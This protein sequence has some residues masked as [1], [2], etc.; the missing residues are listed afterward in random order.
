MMADG[1]TVYTDQATGDLILQPAAQAKSPTQ[2]AA[3]HFVNLAED[4]VPTDILDRLASSTSELVAWDEQNLAPSREL[5]AK[6]IELLGIGEESKPDDA[7]YE[8]S[9]TSDHP[10]LL[11][12]VTRFQSKAL[13]ALL[14][15][16]DRVCR[17]EAAMDLSEIPDE[18]MR[19]QVQEE[20]DN[21]GERVEKFMADYL[22][23]RHPSY[24]EDTDMILFDC[25]L[26]GLGVRKVYN[27]M[28]RRSQKTRVDKVDT[29]DL[30]IS[31]DT[32]NM[33]S[34]RITHRINMTTPDL[35]R[36]IQ[37]GVYRVVRALSSGETPEGGAITDAM[38]RMHGLHSAY[39]TGETHKLYEVSL[40]LFLDA[41]PH[42]DGLARPYIMTIHASTQEVL[43]IVRNWSPDDED[44]M[45]IERFV[46]YVYS[47]GKS[48]VMGLGLGALLANITR[49]LRTAQRRGLEAGYLQ[50]HPS[51][52]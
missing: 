8:K 14:P 28:S 4:T 51:G 23:K 24:S 26:H 12:A 32:K 25:G 35:I 30:I 37:S 48:A 45:P 18:A 10:L 29:D 3:G 47:P 22:L 50:N 38:D 2:Q 21:A 9:D 43:S 31:Y 16:P 19:A 41:D 44:E 34:G 5:A 36:N 1:S 11:T 20:C 17:T 42:P 46:G 13:S 40:E 15:S 7:E 49:S 33:R 27:D 39:R 52:F 6:H